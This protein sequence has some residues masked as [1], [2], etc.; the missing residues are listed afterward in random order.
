MLKAPGGKHKSTALA[1]E[2]FG[3]PCCRALPRSTGRRLGHALL[4]GPPAYEGG[5]LIA[6]G[7]QASAHP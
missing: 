7:Q 4:P 1:A 5:S 3:T 6:A 2:P